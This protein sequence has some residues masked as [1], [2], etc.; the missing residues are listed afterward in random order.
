[1]L[2]ITL[3]I[4]YLLRHLIWWLVCPSYE[5]LASHEIDRPRS[6]AEP[7][8]S[9]VDDL[10][11][12]KG[13]GPKLSQALRDSGIWSF[14]QLALMSDQQL[15]AALERADARISNSET[16][17]KQAELAAHGAWDELKTYQ[18]SI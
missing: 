4:L 18:Q 9:R 13:I 10:T 15:T 17:K 7:E 14:T 12:I 5:R 2:L 8:S 3:P 11:V 6:Y 1:V 16:W